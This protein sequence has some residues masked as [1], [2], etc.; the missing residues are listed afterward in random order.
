M[1]FLVHLTPAEAAPRLEQRC[2]ALD[3]EIEQHESGLR[4]ASAFF[5]RVNLVESEYLLA[6]LRAER[7]WV[8][9]LAAEIREQEL[10]WD[11]KSMLQGARADLRSAGRAGE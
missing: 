1:S 9:G 10:D 11:L 2:R 3:V 4:A 8:R 6:M 7:D 5:D